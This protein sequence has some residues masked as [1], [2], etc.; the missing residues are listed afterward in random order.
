MTPAQAGLLVFGG[1]ILGSILPAYILGRLLKKIDIREHGAHNAGIL[2]AFHVLGLGPA[3]ATAVFDLAK[4]LLAMFIAH[5]LGA[6]LL[7]VHL[8]GFAAVAGHVFPF[9]LRFR[10][11][12]GAATATA[13]L[14]A[15]FGLFLREGWFPLESLALLLAVVVSFV[16][17]TRKGEFVGLAVLPVLGVL[18]LVFLP[19]LGWKLTFLSVAA[20]I[21]FINILNIWKCGLLKLPSSESR[22]ELNWRHHARPLAVV[23]VVHYFQ[24]DKKDTLI[25][26]GSIALVFLIL[27]LTR[28]IS[29]K[30][31]IFFFAK[32]KDLYKPKEHRKF[33]S[34]TLFL[35]AAF[36]TILLFEK[37]IAIFAVSYLI[38]GD[39]FS[40]FFGI[41][42]GRTRIFEKSFEGSLAHL[43]GCLV[44]GYICMQVAPVPGLSYLVGALTASAAELLPLGVDDNFS[45]ALLS[46]SVMTVFL[47]F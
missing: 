22:A 3:V 35:F 17:I 36:L 9:Y 27:D 33:S 37:N 4:G 25:L 18:S 34:I 23:L 16:F 7:L 47:L 41:A 31:N 30:V 38:F 8:A 21:L 1:Y 15:Y 28:L 40:K 29:R 42:F 32:V 45:V 44:A 6:S 46:A 24:T 5:R 39:F 43:N 12:Q 14:V 2:N 20:Y 26:I 13:I 11:G 19:S 10:G